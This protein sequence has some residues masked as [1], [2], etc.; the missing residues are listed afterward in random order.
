MKVGLFICD[1]VNPE[2]QH[3][4]GDYSDM[5]VQLF[6]HFEFR[7]YDIING[8]YPLQ[9]DECE[10]YMATGSRHSVYEDL[11]WIH[12][13]KDIIR[14]LYNQQRYFVG[15]CFG[16]QLMAAA[17]GGTVAK[18]P[19][20]WCVGVHSFSIARQ[21]EWMKPPATSIQLLMMCQD[22]VL[23]LPPD[24]ERL[25]G[26]TQCPNAIIQV[27]S[28]MLGIQ[29]HPEFPVAYDALLM[30]L[31]VKRMGEAVVQNGIASLTL[32]VHTDLIKSWIYEFVESTSA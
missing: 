21:K 24:A 6:T 17:L 23:E 16:H 14:S 22:Q 11:P 12:R 32:A 7:F 30:N 27:G 5:F 18:S 2:Y 15:C 20:G 10:L 3:E 28:T 9:L 29:A 25:A 13:L 26:N 19:N 1:H 31:R 8:Q 4:F